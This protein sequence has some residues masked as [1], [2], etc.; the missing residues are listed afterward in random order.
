MDHRARITGWWQGIGGRLSG[1]WRDVQQT[2]LQPRPEAA[3]GVREAARA[4]APVIWMLGMVGTGKSSI[5]RTLTGS[6]EAEIG[7]GFRPCTATARIFDF[8]AEAPV[9]RF[10][11]T[12]GLGEVAYDP[13]EDLALCE[14]QAHLVIA[15]VRAAEPL[16]AA[17]LDALTKVRR[18]HPDWPVVV[19]QTTLHDAYPGQPHP[20]PYPFGTDGTQACGIAALD[21]SLAAQRAT[22]RALPGKAPVCFAPI[23]FTLPDDG[24][25][26]HDYGSDVLWSMLQSGAVEGFVAMMRR[27]AQGAGSSLERR[28]R[29]HVQGYALAAGAIDLVPLAGAVAVPVVQG[30]A[31]HTLGRLYGVDWSRRTLTEFSASLGVGTLLHQS[32]LFGLRQLVKLIPGFGQVAGAAAASALSFAVTYGLGHAAILYLSYRQRGQTPER[33][34]VAEEFRRAMSEAARLAKSGELFQRDAGAAA[35]ADQEQPR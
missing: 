6:S 34:A 12:R 8:P 18:R 27:T 2:V 19:A 24:L 11:D 35:G 16:P 21:R 4:Q 1:W 3:E 29:A 5:I 31:L 14:A 28:A 26:P 32:G 17:V 20:Q 23:D 22:L 10:L 33:A 30:K 15:V 7:S 13:G 25:P 9:V